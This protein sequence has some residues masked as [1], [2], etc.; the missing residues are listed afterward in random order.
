MAIPKAEVTE[1]QP[2]MLG[3]T[4]KPQPT[5]FRHTWRNVILQRQ[6]SNDSDV[7]VTSDAS[8][9]SKRPTFDSD[10]EIPISNRSLTSG[11]DS[12]IHAATHAPDLNRQRTRPL[13]G[14]NANSPSCDKSVDKTTA[15]PRPKRPS[16]THEE[17]F[18]FLKPEESLTL[19]EKDIT[20]H[21]SEDIRF[22]DD[23]VTSDSDQEIPKIPP[24]PMKIREPPTPTDGKKQ[25]TS[26]HSNIRIN[27]PEDTNRNIELIRQ[28]TNPSHLNICVSPS[29]NEEPPNLQISHS[30]SMNQESEISSEIDPPSPEL[31]N[32]PSA[33]K[34]HN[35]LGDSTNQYSTSAENELEDNGETKVRNSKKKI[36]PKLRTKVS[37]PNAKPPLPRP[38]S[39]KSSNQ[40]I[41]KRNSYR[42][43]GC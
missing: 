21:S 30:H 11:T 14:P 3:K 25:N 16:F 37:E 35:T 1:E 19:D 39:Y 22:E 6:V 42:I 2:K 34:V 9:K 38:K 8:T 4:P 43:F 15:P 33:K 24:P 26:P 29:E 18:T 23:A 12:P 10:S 13:F 5:N 32:R 27:V 36:S 40:Q 20:H 41:V 28:P 31:L 7:T 17:D